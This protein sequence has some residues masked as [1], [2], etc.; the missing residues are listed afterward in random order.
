MK[1][2]SLRKKI[3]LSALIVSGVATVVICLVMNFVLIPKIEAGQSMRCFDM[4][5]TGYTV[6]EARDFVHHLSPEAMHTYL[7]VQLPLDFF[8]PIFYTVFFMLLWVVL[9]GKPNLVL[10]LPGALAVADYLENSLV[11]VML[12]NADF[13]RVVARVASWATMIKTGLMYITIV[14]LVVAAVFCGFRALRR[15]RQREAAPDS[16]TPEE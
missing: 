11:I 5:T 13:P 9:H 3:I 12:K 1:Q 6:E 8:Y 7:E 2:L 15:R 16:P 4:C 10:A 14:V